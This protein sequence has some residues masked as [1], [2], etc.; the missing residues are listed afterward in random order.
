M[1]EVKLY[2]ASSLDGYIARKD[3]KLD[4]LDDLPN[5][6]KSDFGYGEFY[7]EIDVIVMGRGTYQEV[8][9]FDVD[10]PYSDC[11]CFVVSSDKTISFRT[12][13]TEQISKLN[14]ES[15][16]RIRNAS[17]SNVWLVGGGKLIRSFLDL[18]EVDEMIITIISRTIGEG[19][20]LFSSPTK[21]TAWELINTQVFNASVLNLTYRKA[22]EV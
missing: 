5:P 12:P 13:N 4:W 9:G 16:Q 17:Q 8:L 6:D 15:M 18:G 2:I 21:D 10:W 7:K 1:S 22:A 11:K 3:G 14:Q 19:I 20:P